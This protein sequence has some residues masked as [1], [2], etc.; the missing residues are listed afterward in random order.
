MGF[1]F[2]APDPALKKWQEENKRLKRQKVPKSKRP[3]EPE[4]SPH[5]PKKYECALTLL[6]E[7]KEKFSDFKVTAVLADC[8]YGNCLFIEGI[9]SLWK[10]VQ[11]ITKMRKNQ[12]IRYRNSE[13]S[14]GEHFSIYGGWEQNVTLR[15]REIK[16]VTAGGGRLYVPSHDQKR[17]VIALKYEGEIEYRY[18]MAS[19]LSWTMKEIINTFTLRWLIEVFFEDWSCYQ[20]FCNLAKQ[21]G[22]EGSERP[23]ILSLLFDHCFLFYP[24]QQLNIEAKVSLA[25]FG[26]LVEKAKIEAFYHFIEQLLEEDSPKDKL[27]NLIDQIGDVFVLRSSK[28]H[29]NGTSVPLE[30]DRLVA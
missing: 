24:Q 10:S 26:S 15:G 4:R 29:L 12:N 30:P 20:G 17:F 18:L 1:K 3:K 28:K 2:Y 6:K 27:K 8:L 11:V 23:L 9:E 7:F 16:K 5:Y 13:Y 22:V 25:T 14:C 21:C 19:N